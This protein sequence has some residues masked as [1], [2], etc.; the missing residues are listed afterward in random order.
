MR[1]FIEPKLATL[2]ARAPK[3][4]WLP[5]F[6]YNGYRVQIHVSNGKKKIYTRNGLNWTK[7]FSRMRAERPQR[8]GRNNFGPSEDQRAAAIEE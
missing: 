4:D 6:K 1:G 5:E 8:L 2:K 7:R 3:G